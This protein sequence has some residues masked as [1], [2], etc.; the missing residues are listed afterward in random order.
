MIAKPLLITG[1]LVGLAM[2]AMRVRAKANLPRGIRNKNPGNII[3]TNDVWIGQKATQ[4]DAKYVQFDA[5][6][7][8]FRAMKRLLDSYQRLG[9]NSIEGIVRRWSNDISEQDKRSYISSV[10]QRTKVG[11]SE[12][13][14]FDNREKL[15]DLMIAIHT[16]E[17]GAQYQDYYSRDLISDAIGRA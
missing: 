10:V 2:I 9:I 14:P 7:Y 5:P 6:V 4:S 15:I 3:R 1:L 16:H 8:G 12:V 13:Y 17:N 11:A